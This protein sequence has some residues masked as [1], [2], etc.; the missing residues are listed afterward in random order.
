MIMLKKIFCVCFL[1]FLLPLAA[2]ANKSAPWVGASLAGVRCSGSGQGFGPF[3][4]TS[5][6]GENAKNLE[7]VEAHHFTPAV[8]NLVG[9][10][11][12]GGIVGDLDYTLRAWPN[13]HR[14][15]LS[16]IKYQINMDSKANID[17]KAAKSK[18]P[19]PPE[20]Y[21]QRAIQY[22]PSDIV[23][24]SLYGYFLRKI[25]HIEDAVKFYEKAMALDPENEKVAYS[26]S[27]VLID[28]KHYDE[29]VKFAKIAYHHGKA[30]KGLKEMLIKLGVWKD[31]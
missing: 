18:L 6:G 31:D 12:S 4:Y 17:S 15:L 3:D 27:L 28:L 19:T 11:D 14:A 29:A 21:L 9:G 20:C 8:E 22:S 24:Y 1:F 13:H 7:I 5:R 25:G 2:V 23:P 16:L 26:Y 10:A 30:P